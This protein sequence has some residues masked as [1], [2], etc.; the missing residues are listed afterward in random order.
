MEV[1]GRGHFHF[2]GSDEHL[3]DNRI[4]RRLDGLDE[5]RLSDDHASL[6]RLALAA[7]STSSLPGGFEP[8]NIDSTSGA[9]GEP[10]DAEAR[11]MRFAFAAHRE[12]PGT[13]YRIVDGAV[14]DNVPIERALRSARSRV[15]EHRPI[16]G[17]GRAAPVVRE[18][19]AGAQWR[20]KRRCATCG[21][22][23]GSG[24]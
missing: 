17:R 7:R 4:P 21:C 19:P 12:E 15:S 9:A 11:G 6:S 10:E 22:G 14:F 16:P 18:P 5:T 3:L 8:A 23:S 24:R 13:P 1:E 20:S 2:V